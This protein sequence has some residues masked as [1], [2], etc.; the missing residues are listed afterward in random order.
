M[1]VYCAPDSSFGGIA[2]FYYGLVCLGFLWP[3]LVLGCVIRNIHWIGLGFSEMSC[4]FLVV[5]R[6]RFLTFQKCERDFR[7]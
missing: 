4:G 7:E 2:A 6:S 5:S 1:G 3:V